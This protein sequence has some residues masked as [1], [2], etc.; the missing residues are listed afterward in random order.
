MIR[1]AVSAQDQDSWRRASVGAG[2]TAVVVGGEG[3]MG[4][5]FTRFLADQGYITGALDL[6]TG[7]EQVALAP[8]HVLN[9]ASQQ[10]GYHTDE[11]PAQFWFIFPYDGRPEMIRSIQLDTV[12]LLR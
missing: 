12:V 10:I 8:I 9:L 11:L 4:R 6:G 7:D 5:W 3:R 2:K 1:A